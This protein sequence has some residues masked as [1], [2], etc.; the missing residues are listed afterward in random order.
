MDWQQAESDS[1]RFYHREMFS[2]FVTV[3][4]KN[5]LQASTGLRSLREWYPQQQ[6]PWRPA[7][8]AKDQFAEILVLRQQQA[9][10]S[11]RKI[12]DLVICDPAGE[13]G[14]IRDIDPVLAEG[15]DQ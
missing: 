4:A 8:H 1:F 11:F 7:L 2:Q 9:R 12:Q 15:F 6:H 5:S 3:E 14:N 13:L 10:L